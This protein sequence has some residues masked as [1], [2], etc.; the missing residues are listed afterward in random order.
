ML[1]T[2]ARR[3]LNFLRLVLGVEQ[4]SKQQQQLLIAL[5]NSLKYA[6]TDPGKVKATVTYKRCA[7]IV[8]LLS[9]MDVKGGEY[10]RVGRDGDGG[11]VMLCD[12]LSEKVDAAYSF[13]IGDDVSWSDAI[14]GRG[15]DVFMYDHTISR[16]PKRHPKFH[17]FKT[18]LAGHKK[19]PALAT[20]GKLIIENGHAM[21]KRLIMKIDIEG[22][23]W[24]AF[25]E[26]STEVIGQFSQLVVEFH[27]LS[28]AVDE[29]RYL[30][31]VEV[32]KKINQTHQSIHVH[33]NGLGIPLWIGEFVLPSTLE[34][35]Y[36]RRSDVKDRL[37]AN[38]R[39]FPTEIDQ[40][41]PANRHDIYLGSFS[42]E[43]RGQ[44]DLT[45][46]R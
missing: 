37:V 27:G 6:S 31:I 7:E 14:A 3:L 1:K 5:G 24:D 40:P 10:A 44:P 26:I 46:P 45:V 20:L 2:A 22:G 23:E 11:Y 38:T 17:F 43:E 39:Q 12:P 32:L 29:K 33:A 18:G 35:T 13:G 16:L 9:P 30:L 36:V 8:S 28:V 4:L 15:I 41:S 34:V 25:D 42:C 19:G 21:C